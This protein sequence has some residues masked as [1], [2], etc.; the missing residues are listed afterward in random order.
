[1]PKLNVKQK[2]WLISAHVATGGIWF[3][4]ALCMVIIALS[5]QTTSNGDELYAVNSVIKLLDDFVVIPS[6]ILSLVTGGFLCWLSVWGFV[7]FYWVITKWVATV[8][9]I[10]FGTFW[11]GPWTNTATAIA[12]LER[13]KALTNPVF[14]FDSR[15][16]A[17]GGAIQSISIL[18][19][20]FISVIKPWGKRNTDKTDKTDKLETT[21]IKS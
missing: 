14:M 10:V 15:A 18:V 12:D 4:T 3:G 8:T 6:A 2:N 9:L 1:M 16:A 21:A 17:I 7:K 19:I 11:L 20:I 5:H 13:S